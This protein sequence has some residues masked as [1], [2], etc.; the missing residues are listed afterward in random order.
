MVKAIA[1]NPRLSTIS[2][3]PTSPA[4]PPAAPKYTFMPEML[5]RSSLVLASSGSSA[6]YGPPLSV[7]NTA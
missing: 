5:T 4:A 2:P 1:L 3:L 7:L 6:S